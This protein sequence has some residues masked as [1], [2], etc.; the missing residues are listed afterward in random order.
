MNKKYLILSIV[1][2]G[3]ALT[4]CGDNEN[5]DT[6]QTTKDEATMNP[7]LS[8]YTTPFEVPPFDLIKI[9]HYIPAFEAG[10]KQQE[11]EIDA[12]INNEEAPS[13]ENTILALENSGSILSKVSSVFYN[14]NSANT[15][16]EMQA[17]AQEIS[18]MMSAHGDNI[19]LNEKLFKRIQ[20]LW[21]DRDNLGLNP[22]QHKLLEKKYKSFV[23]GGANLSEESKEEFRAIN[24]QLS[25]LS[26]KFGQNVLSETNNYQLIIEDEKDLAGLPQGIIDAAAEEAEENG[27]EGK[28]LFTLQNPSVLPFL[29]YADNRELRKQIWD[30]M[31]SRGNQGNEFDN[32]KIILDIIN[33]RRQRAQLLGYL[34]HASYKLEQSMAGN[35]KEV[36]DLLNQLWEPALEKA[37]MEAKDLQAMIKA[38]GNDF[39]LAPYDWRYYTEKI[40]QQRYD[41]D[42]EQVKAYFSLENVKNGIFTLCDKLFGL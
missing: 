18:P 36:Y 6:E 1:S 3:L 30:A 10:I 15:N 40:R 4:S 27:L 20:T 31:Q 35:P 13:F 12:I 19:S 33:L 39:E 22:E 8:D 38:E 29:Q 28:W 11:E 9:E 26:I 14:L 21:E 24:E 17:I 2:L 41:L 23:R 7:F 34:D 16:D 32:N 25:L 37:K 42:E 5:K